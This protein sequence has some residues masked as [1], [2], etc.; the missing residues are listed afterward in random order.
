MVIQFFDS[1]ITVLSEDII[2][3]CFLIYMSV[4]LF[5]NIIKTIILWRY[6]EI[7]AKKKP[8]EYLSNNGGEQICKNSSHS[9]AFKMRHNSCE[10][11]FG[12]SVEQGKESIER[13]AKKS[14]VFFFL[15]IT[16][17]DLGRV[18]LPYASIL[19]T[20]FSKISTVNP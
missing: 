5:L 6:K 20:L 4:V 7:E 19:F 14:G 18:V 11:C 16:I 2:A 1:L 13:R 3:R 15:I 9:K 8:C 12:R 17:A 10:G